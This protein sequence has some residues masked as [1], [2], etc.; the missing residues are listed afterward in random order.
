MRPAPISTYGVVTLTGMSTVFF[1][2][3]DTR[4][5]QAPTPTAVTV[6]ADGEPGSDR[7]HNAALNIL[8]LGLQSLAHA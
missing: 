5:T 1:M 4:I 7:D 6:R 8:A 3:S 2:P